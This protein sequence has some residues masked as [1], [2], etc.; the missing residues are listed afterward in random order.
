MMN[1]I[2]CNVLTLLQYRTQNNK[3]FNKL[4]INRIPSL[5][6]LEALFKAVTSSNQQITFM[7]EEI[8]IQTKP[9][10]I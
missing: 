6:L 3:F 7:L 9:F 1:W 5:K 8:C 4:N 2:I 10:Q